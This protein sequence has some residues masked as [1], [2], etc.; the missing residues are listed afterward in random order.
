MSAVYD[1]S[2]FPIVNVTINN[3][4]VNDII[5]E[6]FKNDWL[7][8]FKYDKPWIFIFNTL[9]VGTVPVKYILKIATFVKKIKNNPQNKLERS[10]IITTNKNVNLL[11]RMVFNITAPSAPLHILQNNEPEYIDSILHKLQNNEQLPKNIKTYMPI[12]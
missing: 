12:N 1:Y 3:N 7:E 8:C 9:N 6:K 11:L 10:I 5:F 2:Q 4:P